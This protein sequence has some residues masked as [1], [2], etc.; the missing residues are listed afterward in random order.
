MGHLNPQV[1]R[2]STLKL[3]PAGEIDTAGPGGNR[4]AAGFAPAAA[5][6]ASL[7]VRILKDYR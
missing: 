1:L 6:S 5:R 3:R 4:W 2:S 7:N